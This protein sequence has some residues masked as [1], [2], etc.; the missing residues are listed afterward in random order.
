V[1]ITVSYTASDNDSVA[2]SL[3]VT[4]NEAINGL[5]DGDTSPDWDITDDHH[6]SLRAERSGTG[7][8]RT[9]TIKVTCADP[10]GNTVFKTT[11]VKVPKSQK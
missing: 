11:T 7:S 2:C 3:S 8:G 10:S 6:L 9:Y 4:S 5:G 1:P